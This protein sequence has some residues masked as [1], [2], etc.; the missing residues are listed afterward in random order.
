MCKKA[1]DGDAGQAKPSRACLIRFRVLAEPQLS[2]TSFSVQVDEIR[3]SSPITREKHHM[4]V[5]QAMS[6]P[7]NLPVERLETGAFRLENSIE[8]QTSHQVLIVMAIAT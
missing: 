1:S 8:G 3:L 7:K 5:D 4:D 2:S 6:P